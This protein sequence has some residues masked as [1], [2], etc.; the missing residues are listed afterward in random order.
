MST[1]YYAVCAKCGEY[2]M[3]ARRGPAG[4]RFEEDAPGLAARFIVKHHDHGLAIRDEHAEEIERG[5]LWRRVT[6]GGLIRVECCKCG[7]GLVVVA[8]DGVFPTDLFRANGDAV[9]CSRCGA[10][11][12]RA[13]TQ[14]RGPS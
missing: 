13:A 14:R 1:Y 9:E 5:G 11:D 12:W 8:H 6:G 10:N 2:T 7:A 4:E 3:L